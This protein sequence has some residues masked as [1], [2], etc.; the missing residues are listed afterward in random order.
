MDL[1][2]VFPLML[3]LQIKPY[4]QATRP[5]IL[6]EGK[7]RDEAS[8]YLD[9]CRYSGV[10]LFNSAIAQKGLELFSGKM[11][12]AGE[13]LR[14]IPQQGI[15]N[16]LLKICRQEGFNSLAV[17]VHGKL[18]PGHQTG[19]LEK[20]VLTSDGRVKLVPEML[21]EAAGSLAGWFE[22]EKKN[23]D[24][25]RLITRR[26]VK[27]HN[28]W[29]HNLES[30]VEPPENTNYLYMNPEDASELGISEGDTVDVAA[31]AGSVRVP[32]RL[33]ADLMPKTVA[34][35]HGWGHQHS[36]LTVAASTQGVNANILAS[37]GP[38]HVDPVSGMSLLTGIVVMIK[39]SDQLR[40]IR[41]WSGI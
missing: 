23:L 33:L 3:G 13:S 24:H 19:F 29:T 26:A 9:L 6:P 21:M 10:N 27:T 18:Q 11:I 28:S 32:V 22:T 25:F 30:F 35:P 4:L 8:I 41:S 12:K 37:S 2:F 15:L 20:R 36:G 40:N 5:V 39:K 34:L 14:E 38:E 31:R 17:Q 16:L 1:P 7:Q